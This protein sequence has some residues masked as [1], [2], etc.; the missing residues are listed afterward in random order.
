MHAYV[1][2]QTKPAS[3]SAQLGTQ[4]T[5]A[6]CHH[7]KLSL[8]IKHKQRMYIKSASDKYTEWN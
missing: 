1:Y 4:L 5:N 2:T 7:T 8:N 3:N 6:Y